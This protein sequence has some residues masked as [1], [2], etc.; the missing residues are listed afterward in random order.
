[1]ASND[2]IMIEK[3]YEG[4][5]QIINLS[6]E[7]GRLLGIVDSTY[8]R[9]PPARLRRENK[10]K[11]IQS[12]LEIEGNILSVDQ[13]S[14][15]FDNKKVVGP[16]QDILEVQNAISVYQDL[17][18][19]D[20]FKE[21]SYLEAH[22]ILMKGLVKNP[23]NYRTGNVGVFKGDQ[24]AHM[25]PPAWNVPNLMGN[26]FKYLKENEDN[27]V[28]KSCVFHYEMEFI[29]PFMDGNGRMGR[30][31]QTVILMQ[32]NPIFE[33]LPIELEIRNSAKEYYKALAASDKE[34]I[35]TRFVAYLLAVIQMSLAKQISEQRINLQ[36]EERILY[37]KEH[38]RLRTFTRKDYMEM[39]RDISSATA[40]RDLRVGVEKGILKREGENRNTTYDFV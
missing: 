30:L 23:G 9:K 22:H 24:V 39:F 26:L 14:A 6:T 11:T 20:A 27:L 3:Y 16:P 7:I 13:V 1:M 21:A 37:F 10:I 19:F 15:I 29:H 38:S 33:F 2:G 40:T 8:L 28:I 17:A 35:A 5:S 4:T 31:W 18:R 32:E 36:D 34:G 12:S 25:A